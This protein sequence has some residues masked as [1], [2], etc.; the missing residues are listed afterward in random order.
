MK[1]YFIISLLTPCYPHV[2]KI[3]P[4]L[5][6]LSLYQL[7]DEECLVIT[8]HYSVWYHKYGDFPNRELIEKWMI[9]DNRERKE[10]YDE[11]LKRTRVSEKEGEV[12]YRSVT[13]YWKETK[14]KKGRK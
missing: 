14:G 13:D 1:K 7:C 6:T 4:I 2:Y 11:T 9:I 5:I 3:K 8:G 12:F 10:V